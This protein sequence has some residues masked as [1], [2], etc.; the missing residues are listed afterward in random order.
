MVFSKRSSKEDLIFDIFN[1]LILGIITLIVLYPLYFMIIASISDPN[2]V[3][4][5]K[6]ILFPKNITFEGYQKI[7]NYK[8]IWTGYRNTIIYSAVGALISVVLTITFAYPLSRKDFFGRRFF[9]IVVLITM[10]FNGGMIP[11]Y[12]VVRKLGMINTIWAMVLPNAVTAF[13]II[14]ARTFFNMTIPEELR[15]A[16]SIDGCTDFMFFAKIVVPLS[17]PIIAVLTLFAIVGQWNGFFDALLYLTKE[18]LYPLQLVLRNILIQS[19]SVNQLTESAATIIA[20]Q[21]QAE[22]MKYGVIIVS[23]VPL[24]IFYP[25]IQ[26]YFAKGMMVGSVKG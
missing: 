25:F 26:K 15:E 14:I 5:G 18:N 2:Y 22:L 24:L 16:A 19:Q 9:M 4:N 1:F 3:A 12:L 7:I 13:N 8:A 17:K 10:F 11:T 23:S 6:V 21:R 20:Q